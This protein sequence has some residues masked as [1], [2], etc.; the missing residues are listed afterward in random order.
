MYQAVVTPDPGGGSGT[1]DT[2]NPEH[3]N[4]YDLTGNGRPDIVL[5]LYDHNIDVFMNN[6][7]GTF[8]PAVAYNTETPNS[9]GGYPRGVVFGDF[10]GDGKVDI[11]SLNFGE[12]VPADQSAPQPGSVGILYGNGDG[13]FQP[14]I[15][16]TPFLLP[17]S[18]AVGDF[19]NDGLPDLAVM[20]N[21]TGHSL[22]V[23]LNQPN[24]AQEPPTVSGISPNNGPATGGTVVT[25][26]GTNFTGTS[27][28]NFGNVPAT[29]FTVNSDQSITATAP[30]QS[31]GPVDV[32]VYNAG[33]SGTSSADVFTYNPV[34]TPPAV[35][36]IN[37]SVG[38]TNG[39]TVVTIT[40]T[41][42][43][44]ASAV[45]FGLLGSNYFRVISATSIYAVAPPEGPGTVD[46]TV[47][48]SGG[49]SADVQADKFTYQSPVFTTIAVSPSTATVNDGSAQQFSAKALDQ[50]GAAL[51]TQPTFAWSVSGLGSINPTSGLYSAPAMGNGGATVIA[52][53]GS[54][55]GTASVNVVAPID[56]WTG[57]GTTN[58]WSEAANWS[59][60]A[61]PG[62]TSTVQFG[63]NSSKN[64]IVD[65][66]FGGTVGAVQIT[67]A[68]KGMV[69]LDRS[70]AVAGPF[71]AAGGAYDAN[72]FATTVSGLTKLY[73]GA[74][75]ASTATQTLA[76]GLMVAGGT[77]AGSTGAVAVLNVSISSGIVYAPFSYLYV[78]G[79]NFTYTGGTFN[80]DNGTVMFVGTHVSP[81]VSVG[82]GLIHF[83][84]FTNALSAGNY[85]NG[86]T[87]VGTLTVAGTFAWDSNANPIYGNI[88]A[89][90]N[91]D[92]ENHGGI[93]NPYLVLDGAA[94]QTIEDLSGQGGGQ[95]RTITIN[96][97]GGV[98]TLACNPI[99]FSGL[100]LYAGTVNTG[101][102]SWVVAG[103]LSA[104]PGL[105]L[106]NIEVAGTNVTVT[107]TDLHVGNVLFA[108][109][110][111]GLTA[112]SGI[113]WVSGNWDN[114]ALASFNA[115]TA[116]V[117]IDGPGTTQLL[118]GGGKAF[119][120]LIVAPDS[121]L[122]LQSDTIVAGLFLSFGTVNFNG[123]KVVK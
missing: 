89:Q 79:G 17:G 76:G 91:V 51:A 108:A 72:G 77:F 9:V 70:L 37:P 75:L 14:S 53:S 50:F 104:S 10:N 6:G 22:G 111:D 16:Y 110:A 81:T 87:I 15:E 118:N 93:G 98:V 36:A 65:P 21:Y 67:S 82:T 57:L 24:T 34:G 66:G 83:Y 92:D 94:N 44:G 18:L 107:S 30:G 60:N 35:T 3:V 115:N 4:A 11:A 105:N 113:L 46:I 106:G 114:S 59:L 102:H 43:T 96:K 52:T 109:A 1:G 61:V 99:D 68:Y 2:I 48:T 84:N 31:A 78:A 121:V 45:K 20:Q 120:N 5:S 28:V 74:Y 56:I 95:F 19:N 27:Q 41:N 40:G 54:I 117:V 103:P 32:T 8:K 80:P 7:D 12:P 62:P 13:T 123:H 85:P 122:E 64:A 39:G 25:I 97:T 42:F 119:W 88:E 100:T 101:A 49:T 26:A 69:S 58:N 71:T 63:V 47:T 38:S 73:G 86:M 29:S 112:P 23:M 116:T 33:A 55:K 90:G